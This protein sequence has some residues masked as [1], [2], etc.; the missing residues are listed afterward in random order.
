M[1]I[2]F[3]FLPLMAIR[4]RR[5]HEPRADGEVANFDDEELENEEHEFGHIEEDSPAHSEPSRYVPSGLSNVT[6]TP[7]TA[8]SMSMVNAAQVPNLPM[9]APSQLIAQQQMLQT[10]M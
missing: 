3:A 5:I 8:S 7:T 10:S 9:A 6:S 4:H 2:R 1:T